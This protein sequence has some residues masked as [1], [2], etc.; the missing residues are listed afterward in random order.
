M[1]TKIKNIEC[2][3]R[4]LIPSKIVS[5]YLFNDNEKEAI[6]YLNSLVEN[7]ILKYLNG[8]YPENQFYRFIDD[9]YKIDCNICP[10]KGCIEAING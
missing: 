1:I 8:E 7:G 10:E 3:F 4:G 6:E 5:H 2:E 9:N